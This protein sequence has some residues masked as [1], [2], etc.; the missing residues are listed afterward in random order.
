MADLKAHA[1]EIIREWQKGCSCSTPGNPE[2][3]GACTAGMLVALS[4]TLAE[5]ARIEVTQ[6]QDAEPMTIEPAALRE[7]ARRAYSCA[8]CSG[9]RSGTDCK[10]CLGTLH[11]EAAR[12]Q[13]H[14]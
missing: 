7:F 14:A 10:V 12:L 3:C 1:I 11:A 2:E 8:L 6:M 5:G 9:C 13:V 4:R